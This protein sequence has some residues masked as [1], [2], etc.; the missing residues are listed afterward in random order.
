[1][2]L[3][4]VNTTPA[5]VGVAYHD[6]YAVSRGRLRAFPNATYAELLRQVEACGER[7]AEVDHYLER[8]VKPMFE[9]PG[10][11]ERWSTEEPTC[12]LRLPA[13]NRSDTRLQC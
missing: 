8:A 11:G 13:C 9:R 6:I 10:D 12:P 3:L 7:A 5:A 2:A 1:M 4:A